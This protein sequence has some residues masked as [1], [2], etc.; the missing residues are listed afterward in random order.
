[1][2]REDG[3]GL[4]KNIPFKRSHF[5]CMP[6]V[7]SEDCMIYSY[8]C[9]NHDTFD[10]G[11]CTSDV[12]YVVVAVI[13]IIIVTFIVFEIWRGIF[14]GSKNCLLFKRRLS[15]AFWQHQFNC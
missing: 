14:Y 7:A 11:K 2:K 4:S 1:M 10:F 9:I 5:A 13:R 15:L 6:T 12:W 3:G 8:S